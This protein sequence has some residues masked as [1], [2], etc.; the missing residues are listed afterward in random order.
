VPTELCAWRGCL[1]RVP[2]AHGA[3]AV[4]MNHCAMVHPSVIWEQKRA[5]PGARI[6]AGDLPGAIPEPGHKLTTVGATALGVVARL[7]RPYTDV[8]GMHLESLGAVLLLAAALLLMAVRPARRAPQLTFQLS[9]AAIWFGFGIGWSI[10]HG[11]AWGDLVS[12]AAACGTTSAILGGAITRWRSRVNAETPD[13]MLP[14]DAT[15]GRPWPA[16]MWHRLFRRIPNASQDVTQ[17]EPAV[18]CA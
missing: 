9:S 4:T 1:A 13:A 8:N 11:N 16:R 18:R 17:M 10:V 7:L 5:S 14:A 15:K 6:V 2:E 12:V 3:A